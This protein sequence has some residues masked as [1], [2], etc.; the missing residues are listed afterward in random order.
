[1]S[2]RVRSRLA[3]AL[4]V[5]ALLLAACGSSPGKDAVAETVAG[6]TMSPTRIIAVGDIA[7]PPT[8][9]PTRTTCR[10]AD[11]ARLARNR[12][13]AYVI[14]LGDLQYEKGSFYGFVHSYDESWGALRGRTRPLPGNHEYKTPGAAGYYRYFNRSAPG[15]YVWNV[16][17]WRIYNLN[18]NCDQIDCDAELEWLERDL[19]E[20]P[21]DCSIIAMHHPRFSSGFEHGSNLFVKPFWQV[22]HRHHVDV[23]LAGHDHDYER[24]VRLSPSGVRDPARGIISYVSGAGGKNLYRLGTRKT[25]SE[26]F[27]GSRFGVL[28]LVLREGEWS[29][30]Y[31]TI[32]GVVR[33]SGT[34]QCL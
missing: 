8:A 28:E 30:A 5:P 22:A 32:D 2:V 34:R 4:G 23:A 6:A 1:M 31:R 27:N 33:D 19:A 26:Y 16:G 11:T 17:S 13:P 3:L 20:H 9:R 24:F 14:G 10:Q 21:R 25:G 7:C 18:T 12:N 29:F 15:Y